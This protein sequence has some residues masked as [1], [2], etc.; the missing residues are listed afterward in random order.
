[1]EGDLFG[2]DV[3]WAGGAGNRRATIV[4]RVLSHAG[5]RGRLLTPSTALGKC[6][7]ARCLA[8]TSPRDRRV[9][10]VTGQ[11]SGPYHQV[12]RLRPAESDRWFDES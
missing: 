3:R 7:S 5:T 2:I 11:P 10:V 12:L 9:R 4:A 6:G 1:M 8:V